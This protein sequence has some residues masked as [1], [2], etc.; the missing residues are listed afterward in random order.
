MDDIVESDCLPTKLISFSLRLGTVQRKIKM[1]IILYKES[2][3]NKTIYV[4][5]INKNVLLTLL[6]DISNIYT[7]V[8]NKP[9]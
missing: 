9:T 8:Y 5:V 2:A 3:M 6:Y 4:I 7:S 1:S